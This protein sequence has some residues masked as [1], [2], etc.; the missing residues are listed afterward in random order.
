MKSK[1]S[2]WRFLRFSST[3]SGRLLEAG[4]DCVVRTCV[5]RLAPSPDGCKG[6]RDPAYNRLPRACGGIG[7]RARL[8]ALWGVSPVGVR[9]SL[10]ALRSPRKRGGFAVLRAA[11]ANG[12]QTAAGMDETD[13]DPVG[14]NLRG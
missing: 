2:C 3:I 7:R 8:R 11:I 10:G 1:I 6:S 5:R 13:L 14:L 4:C 12:L 9:V